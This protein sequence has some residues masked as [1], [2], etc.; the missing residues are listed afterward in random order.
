MQTAG[1][2]VQGRGSFEVKKEI[3]RTSMKSTAAARNAA[4]MP[5]R[6]V[7]EGSNNV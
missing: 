2:M 1:A 5:V 3:D 7:H 6:S 4:Y